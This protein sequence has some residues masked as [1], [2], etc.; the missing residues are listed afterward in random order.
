M[1]P[2]TLEFPVLNISV[3]KNFMYESSIL[4]TLTV[5]PFKGST[6]WCKRDDDHFS[7]FLVSEDHLVTSL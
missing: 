3:I 7:L 4:E 6:T 1:L 2:C 5:D